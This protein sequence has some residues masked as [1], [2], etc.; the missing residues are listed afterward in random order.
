MQVR[1]DWSGLDVTGEGNLVDGWWT[2]KE[3]SCS[4]TAA[5]V[6]LDRSRPRDA[7][8]VQVAAD[9]DQIS[10]S[11]IRTSVSRYSRLASSRWISCRTVRLRSRS[12]L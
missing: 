4:K 9:T 12:P 11:R 8:D 5:Q 7:A 2:S 6:K 10:R 3:L 1:V